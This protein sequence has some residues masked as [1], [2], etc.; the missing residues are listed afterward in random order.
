MSAVYPSLAGRSV[1]VTGGGSGIGAAIVDAFVAQGSRVTYLDLADTR[2]PDAATF[3]RCDLTDTDAIAAAFAAIG[4]VDA[5]VNNAAND[6]RHD[7]AEVTSAYF[8]NRIAVNLKHHFFCAQAVAPG[9]KAAGRGAIVNIGSISWRLA[10]PDI[11]IYETAKAGIEGLTRALARDLGTDGIRVTCVVPGGV[12]TP[13]QIALWHNPEV[14]AAMIAA[15]CLKARVDPH[16]VAA[17]VLF[18][19]S[20]DAAMCTAHSY[21]VDAGWS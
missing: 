4:P 17:M 9:M 16:H 20:D 11:P 8:D 5:L 15:Q 14:E 12:R 10:I 13:R 7:I 21:V 1:V 6:D 2:T 3:M 19:C 18:L